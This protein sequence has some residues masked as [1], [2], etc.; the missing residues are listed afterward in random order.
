MEHTLDLLHGILRRVVE[1]IAAGTDNLG[2]SAPVRDKND[3]AAADHLRHRHA[4]V[5]FRHP[6]DT[7]TVA[8]DQLQQDLATDVDVERDPGRSV[9]HEVKD[10]FII[11]GIIG[12]P[13]DVKVDFGIV[14][15]HS[16]ED[17]HDFF[18]LLFRT[19]ATD[20]NKT[21]LAVFPGN[22]R[23]VAGYGRIERAR[24]NAGIEFLDLFSDPVGIDQA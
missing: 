7:E 6:V 2:L 18:D 19:D 21:H 20:A 24:F 5:F 14:D 16:I 15:A 1:D 8:A 10:V 3:A 12:G 11:A 17:R 9:P 23:K 22:S 4:E 13:N